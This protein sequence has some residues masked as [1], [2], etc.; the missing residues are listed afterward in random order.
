MEGFYFEKRMV[1]IF[2]ISISPN[3]Y[4]PAHMAFLR[5]PSESVIV[6][7]ILSESKTKKAGVAASY[8][9]F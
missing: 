6:C 8:T 5:I 2:I 3:A 4:N 9:L 7:Y 1:K